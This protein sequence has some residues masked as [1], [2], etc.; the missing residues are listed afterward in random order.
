MEPWTLAITSAA[1]ALSTAEPVYRA[2]SPPHGRREGNMSQVLT[3]PRNDEQEL[4]P[5][6]MGEQDLLRPIRY[7]VIAPSSHNTQPWRFRV[8]DDQIDLFAD[9]S[10]WLR[11]ADPGRRELHLSLGAALENL[12]IAAEH[13]AYSP[14]VEYFPDPAKRDWIA[15]ISL[16]RVRQTKRPSLFAALPGRHTTRGAYSG[17]PVDDELLAELAAIACDTGIWAWTS[18]DAKAY[19]GV[20]GLIA[21]GDRVQHADPA[22]RRELGESIGEGL[23]GLPR[24]LA[25]IARA[26][27]TRMNFGERLARSDAALITRSG[28][29]LVIVSKDDDAVTQVRAG[30]AL[31]R[32]WLLGTLLGL[33]LHPMSQALQ[34]PELRRE[35]AELIGE[36]GKHPQHLFRI[37]WAG[38]RKSRS[39][40]KNVE[41]VLLP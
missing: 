39:R 11:V 8:G 31:E 13:F 21:R 4:A 26:A 37:G 14:E 27:V 19:D 34:V 35:L 12:V 36:P 32:V 9:P 30:R 40:R 15:R 5:S 22:F 20:A 28:A 1:V 29:L 17:E 10:R 18:T 38:P 33:V 16:A 24:P 25:R 7:A 6:G 2:S 3:V 23:M 41:A